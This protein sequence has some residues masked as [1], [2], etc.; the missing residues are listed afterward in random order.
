MV[1]SF[2]HLFVCLPD[3]DVLVT[4]DFLGSAAL[5]FGANVG[6]LGKGPWIGE[7][8]IL[9]FYDLVRK[10][11]R[12]EKRNLTFFELSLSHDELLSLRIDLESR[13]GNEYPYD[14]RKL[15]CGYYL[16][17]WL[18]G[19][20]ETK[21]EFLYLTPRQALER[22][23]ERYPPIR[24]RQLRT[25]LALLEDYLLDFPASTHDLAGDAFTRHEAL[26]E[27][28]DLVLRLLIINAAESSTDTQG[29]LFLQEVRTLTLQ[30]NG[31]TEAA[32]HL[33]ALQEAAWEEDL[34]S[35]QSAP[36]GPSAS[37]GTFFRTDN[38][39]SGIQI[40]L[41]AGLHNP[42]ASSTSG[43][44]LKEVKFISGIVQQ[45]A[46]TTRG[47]FTLV[48]IDTQR[49][50]TPLRH[51]TSN[52]GSLGYSGLPNSLGLEG[53]YA[54]AW[55]GISFKHKDRWFG[56]RLTLSTSELQDRAKLSAAPGVTFRQK[57]G[58]SI[59]VAKFDF[60]F[61]DG[62]GWLLEQNF[63]L[64]EALTLSLGWLKSPYGEQQL[65]LTTELRF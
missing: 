43:N 10:N 56:G 34:T 12:L 37:L 19:S 4:S 60:N 54:S 35:W 31:G 42:Q 14:F 23:L 55:S 13:L 17:D 52:G 28:E 26:L 36:Q 32:K 5:N 2:G 64:A 22:I 62:A 50:F 59:S 18:S 45:S 57:I 8:Q 11:R 49:A 46:K 40:H 3:S 47:D 21:A 7:Y 24:V 25:N 15:N 65:S 53:L 9:P 58:R 61:S 63:L 29:Y 33:V 1:S 6:P 27:L 44:S 51:S 20:G 30:S 16:W 38:D 39:L 41:E 48:S